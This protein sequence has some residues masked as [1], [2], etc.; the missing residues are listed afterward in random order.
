MYG[1]GTEAGYQRNTGR[2]LTPVIHLPVEAGEVAQ[3]L[4]VHDPHQVLGWPESV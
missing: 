2:A 4:G 3:A 1:A